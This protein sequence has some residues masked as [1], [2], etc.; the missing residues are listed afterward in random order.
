MDRLKNKVAIITGAAN[1]MGESAAHLFSDEGAKV[2]ITDLNESKGQKVAESIGD[3]AIFVKQDVSKEDD[4]K[5]VFSQTIK[6]FGKTDVV[7]NNAGMA[8]YEDIEHVNLDN[9]HKVLSVDLDGVMLG[10]KYG[11]EYMKDHGG[12]II[13]SSSI[14]GLVADPNYAAYDAA[15]GG[16]VMLSKHAAVYCGYHHYNIR[17]NTIHPG[18]VKTPMTQKAL[19]GNMGAEEA[20]I[21]KHPLGRGAEPEEIAKLALFLASDES[22]FST[23]AEFIADGGYTAQ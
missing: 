21:A 14:W 7:Y 2:V 17:V 16:V 8:N 11:I 5:N 4:W 1:G 6:K 23:G 22:S 3:N 20:L 9:W 13:N 18:Y 15:K 12:S 10:T 19:R